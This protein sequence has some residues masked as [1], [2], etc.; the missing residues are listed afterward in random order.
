MGKSTFTERLETD[1]CNREENQV[2]FLEHVIL[3]ITL[4][5]SKRGDLQIFL[6]SPAGTKSKILQKRSVMF[7][8]SQ[9]RRL[10]RAD[11]VLLKEGP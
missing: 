5:H 9:D 4:R 11:V 6:T 2:S 3:R 10:S 1:A 7:T 8:Y